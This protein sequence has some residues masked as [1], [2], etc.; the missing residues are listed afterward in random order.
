MRH[1]P[2]QEFAG[3]IAALSRCQC[4]CRRWDGL[5]VR[6]T[7]RSTFGVITC[8][9]RF[10][11]RHAFDPLGCWQYP[12]DEPLSAAYSQTNTH[13]RTRLSSKRHISLPRTA[14][15]IVK[16]QKEFVGMVAKLSAPAS[17]V[18]CNFYEHPPKGCGRICG[19]WKVGCDDSMYWMFGW[20]KVFG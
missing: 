4:L 13:T 8:L 9:Y 18:V 1:V 6:E 7:L 15:L 11:P 5:F 19:R 10:A 14:V 3:I 2:R 20:V 16:V 17:Q 12:T